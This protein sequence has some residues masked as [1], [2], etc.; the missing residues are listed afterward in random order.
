MSPSFE[1]PILI[2]T[3]DNVST[4]EIMPAG[5]KV[6]PYRSNIPA[7]S[8]F[9]FAQIDETYPER[10]KSYQTSGHIII[11]GEN[12]GQGSSREHAAIAPRF[13]GVRVV[14]A[15]SF[16]RIHRSN[17][18]N[19]GIVP[20]VFSDPKDWDKLAQG[21]ILAFPKLREEVQKGETV[22]IK[23]VTQGYQFKTKH[24]MSPREVEN[25]LAGGLI[26]HYRKQKSK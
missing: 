3:G 5:A 9:V 1:G 22:T 26:S 15:K 19:F 24:T 21:D 13:L 11:G 2:K 23:N 12:Y 17:L 20:L 16:A 25:L 4:D 14:L 8:Q 10:A 7:I 18:S 6:L